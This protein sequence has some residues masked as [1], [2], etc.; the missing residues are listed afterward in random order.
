MENNKFIKLTKAEK[1][2]MVE[3]PEY[4]YKTIDKALFIP[5]K[6]KNDSYTMCAFFIE[7]KGKWYR[8]MSYDCFRFI[9]KIGSMSYLKGDFE[10]DGVQFF[11]G[12]DYNCDYGGEFTKVK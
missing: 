9:N 4:E 5:L 2:K 12:G 8:L 6:V 11:L 1:L 10:N 3:S 7:V